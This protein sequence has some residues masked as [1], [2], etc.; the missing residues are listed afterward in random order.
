MGCFNSV[1]KSESPPRP[2]PANEI[3]HTGSNTPPAAPAPKPKLN[4]AYSDRNYQRPK[5]KSK[6][7]AVNDGPSKRDGTAQLKRDQK[8]LEALVR[9]AKE[10][11]NIMQIQIDESTIPLTLSARSLSGIAGYML[12]SQPAPNKIVV[13]TGAGISTSAG[14]PDFRS[15]KTG[16]Y[17]NLARLDLPN[18]EAVFD[19]EYFRKNPKPFYVLRKE[20]YSSGTFYP[21][22]SHAFLALLH[23]KELLLMLF[24]QNIDGLERKAGIPPEL[25]VEA[26]GSFATQRC[27]DC[28]MGFPDEL[29]KVIVERGEVPHCQSPECNGLVKPDI[30]MF[31]E[32]LPKKFSGNLKVP[33]EADLVLVL[34]TSLKVAPFAGLPTFAKGETPRVLFNKDRVGDFGTRADDVVVLGDCDAGVR[35]LADALGWRQELEELWQG[36]KGKV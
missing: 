15:P 14:I 11:Q 31:G 33:M 34:G 20:M 12:S 29:M 9:S 36:M 6:W 35:K 30:V 4:P 26:H 32:D 13:M 10:G 23:R 24:T 19:L 2:S 27:I 5:A 28:E 3:I 16:L 18:P 7:G 22:V 8:L 17:H 25:I 1:P 21:T